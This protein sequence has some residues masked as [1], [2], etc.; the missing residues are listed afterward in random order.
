MIYRTGQLLWGE[1]YNQSPFQATTMISP[2]GQPGGKM[3][4]PFKPEKASSSAN[5]Q[6]LSTNNWILNCFLK[7]KKKKVRVQSAYWAFLF[8]SGIDKLRARTELFQTIERNLCCDKE[9][10]HRK[11]KRRRS[12]ERRLIFREEILVEWRCLKGIAVTF[13]T[14][15]AISSFFH[16]FSKKSSV[17]LI[18]SSCTAD[19]NWFSSTAFKPGMQPQSGPSVRAYGYC[20]EPCHI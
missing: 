9:P 12:R 3:L 15:Y 10:R 11:G 8:L 19:W 6:P 18:A 14:W 20:Q 5:S 13:A 4:R 17:K 16:T 7:K 2:N 1:Y